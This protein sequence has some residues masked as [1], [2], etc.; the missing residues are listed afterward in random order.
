MKTFGNGQVALVTG[1]AGSMGLATASMLAVEGYR[2]AMAD[3]PGGKLDA[4]VSGIGAAARGF[5]FDVSDAAAT[6]KAFKD[7]ER[8][9]G[10]VEVLINNA[11]ILSNNKVAE[12]TPDEWRK[13]LAVNLDGAFYLSRLAVPGMKAR[14]RGR[15]VNTCSFAMKSGVTFS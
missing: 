11:G 9:L 5:G 15:I 3:L 2:V 8:A 7:I 13:V 14:K 10:P 6:E 1:A 4:A 12:T